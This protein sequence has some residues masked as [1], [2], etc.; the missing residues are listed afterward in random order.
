MP[1]SNLCDVGMLRG[2]TNRRSDMKGTRTVNG[3]KIYPVTN[4]I[5][6][7]FV[8]DGWRHWSRWFV[9]DKILQ[10][11]SGMELKVSVVKELLK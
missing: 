5:V 9:K 4:N 3:V 8:G 11:L 10:R 7:L 1:G 2:T 6:D